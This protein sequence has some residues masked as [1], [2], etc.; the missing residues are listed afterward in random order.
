MV[1]SVSGFTQPRFETLEGV[2]NG[3]NGPNGCSEAGRCPTSS[4]G[5]R[6]G[7]KSTP[8]GST[9]LAGLADLRR[10]RPALRARLPA[11]GLPP[12]LFGASGTCCRD[13]LLKP[14]PSR[15]AAADSIWVCCFPKNCLAV[16]G[17]SQGPARRPQLD[18]RER[19]GEDWGEAE[20]LTPNRNE[21]ASWLGVGCFTPPPAT[22]R[23]PPEACRRRFWGGFCCALSPEGR[24]V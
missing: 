15:D 11:R 1:S 17:R 16:K 13:R 3:R 7:L 9:V 23:A 18:R 2:K 22:W 5:P 10:I 14:A 19:P 24:N 4:P 8:R 12:H 21:H 6:R 20:P